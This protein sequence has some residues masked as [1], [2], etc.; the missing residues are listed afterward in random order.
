MKKSRFNNCFVQYYRHFFVV[1]L[2]YLVKICYGATQENLTDVAAM[3]SFSVTYFST[4]GIKYEQKFQPCSF[5]LCYE[6][7]KAPR[8]PIFLFGRSSSVDHHAIFPDMHAI[9]WVDAAMLVVSLVFF[10]LRLSCPAE[11]LQ[12]NLIVIWSRLL[13][14]KL[15]YIYCEYR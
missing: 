11:W 9:T 1:F 7:K 12:E 14:K 5:L 8:Y 2:N 13:L 15:I 10:E 6:L 3:H 4:N